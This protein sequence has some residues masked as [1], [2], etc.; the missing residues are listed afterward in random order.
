[1][2]PSIDTGM[3]L[4]RI[5]AVL[6]GKKSNFEIDV[7]AP[8]ISSIETLAKVQFKRD[9]LTDIS[10][11]V[12]ADHMRAI[13]FLLS[14]GLVPSNDGRG[15]VLRR[16]IRRAS[17]HAKS[18]GFEGPILYKL[19]ESVIEAMGDAYPE[20]VQERE[21]VSK[22]LMFEEERFNR[23]L[24]Q[25]VKIIDDLIEKLK[26]RGNKI[27]PGYE[28]F[29][30]YD[31]YG[32]PLDLARDIA[33]DNQMLI[34]E[35]GFNKEME[36]QRERA[37]ASWIGEEEA[38]SSIYR[39]LQAEIGE[40]VFVGYETLEAK[41]TVKA[42]LR[43]GKIVLEAQRG[44]EIEIFLD[45]TPFYGES[46]GQVGDVGYLHSDNAE[47]EIYDT[48][49]ELGLH[50]H[51]AKI[52][53][54]TLKVW[55]KVYCIV[56]H[57]KRQ[58]TA[59]HHTATHLLHAALRD[60]AGEHVKQAGSLVSPERLRFDFVHFRPLTKE[61]I[62][63][64]EEFVNDKVLRNIEVQTEITDLQSAIKA[65]VTALF[66]EK[67]G[68]EVRIVRVPGVSAELCG[69]THCKATGDIGL[70]LITSES[71]I[72][73]GIRRIEALTGSSALNYIKTI[74]AEVENL[75]QI[76]KT[77]KLSERVE[78][79]LLEIKD[80]EKEVESLKGKIAS[81]ISSSIVK[82]A[83]DIDG[84]KVISCRVEN[85]E[86]KDLRVLADNIRD[87]IG[88]GIIVLASKK[89][90]QVSI[91]AMVTKDLI[92]TYN[93]GSI[94]KTIAEMAGGKGGGKA[95]MAQGGIS[96]LEDISLLDKALESVY[97]F[98]KNKRTQD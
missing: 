68:E 35:D 98:I 77:D 16:I 17:K 78:R 10:I 31:T 96:K 36:L 84:V 82:S 85:L 70:F 13:T 3:G 40:T 59:R 55:D 38:I 23:T 37:R 92:P 53:R 6:Q 49:K 28:V 60:V 50:S 63:E 18:L 47:V 62:V 32:F 76:L 81:D 97:E 29:K 74:R 7:F 45:V 15:Y 11:R 52:K 20:I 54:G 42:I 79:L 44:D 2:K 66:G 69:G 64:I 75:C 9:S 86:Q 43:N 56:D 61:E 30:L 41:A 8:I 12:I 19:V 94:L 14:E 39:E 91:V 87:R 80:K 95:D 21:R 73:S 46:G 90:S 24:E 51:R 65:G 72:A 22:L 1:P 26:K 89:N 4:E 48:K 33:M 93:A 58:A 67:Y 27:I 34:D 25:G 88:S 5:S 57:I 71:S 83:K